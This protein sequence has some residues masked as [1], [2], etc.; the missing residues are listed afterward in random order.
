MKPDL[1]TLPQDVTVLLKKLNNA[2]YGAYAVGGAVRDGIMNIPCCDY[3][4]TTSATP[5]QI[6]EVFAE[7]KTVDTG[8]KHGTVTVITDAHNVEVTV[9][10]KESGYSDGRHPD[11]VTFASDI[12]DDLSRRDLT[13]NAIAYSPDVGFIDPHG[14]ID[15]IRAGIIRCVGDPEKRFDE[16]KL[17]ILRAVR[18]ASTLGFEIESATASA[19]AAMYKK[20]ECVSRERVFTEM[21]KLICG[22]NAA[23]CLKEYKDLLFEIIPELKIQNGYDQHNPNHCLPLF[24][25]TLSVLSNTEP[26][27]HMRWASLL[28]DTGKPHCQTVDGDG[29]FHFPSHPDKSEEIARGVLRRLRAGGELTDKVCTLIKYHDVRFYKKRPL[30]RRYLGFL[31]WEGFCDLLCLQQ[32]DILSQSPDYR[33]RLD[34]IDSVR[35]TAEQVLASHEPLCIADLAVDGYDLTAAGVKQGK[36][37]GQILSYLLDEVLQDKISNDKEALLACVDRILHGEIT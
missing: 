35:Q 37:V 5:A 13:V 6:K 16:D 10:R 22:K 14:G 28:H 11:S 19:V 24:D 21:S 12:T 30:I 18:F 25:H 26:T 2:G 20:T 33:Y 32:A 1:L 23:K 17:R 29:I 3:D 36:Q 15:D 34:N 9:Y 4:I 8:I 27:V 7:Y 31:G